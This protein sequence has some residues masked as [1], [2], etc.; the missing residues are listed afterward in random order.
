MSVLSMNVLG[1]GWLAA[2]LLGCLMLAQGCASAGSAGGAPGVT[3]GSGRRSPDNGSGPGATAGS[4]EPMGGLGY[5]V[6]AR[7]GK[8]TVTVSAR[9]YKP[10]V[11]IGAVVTN[12]LRHAIYTQDTKSDCSILLLQRLDGASWADVSG[13]ALGRPPAVVAI[14]AS[15]ART[16]AIDPGSIN[17]ANGSPTATLPPGTYRLRLTYGF[18][19]QEGDEPMA[20]TSPP[21]V[22][23]S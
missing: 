14:G 12:G 6:Q 4:G 5:P 20:A 3:A 9:S 23:G 19:F 2:L 22:L 17:F 15:H 1:R 21:F 16:V 11:P 13:C 18:S 8:V 7:D 10:R